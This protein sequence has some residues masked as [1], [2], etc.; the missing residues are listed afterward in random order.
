[1][2]LRLL[3]S[4]HPRQQ[5]WITRQSYRYELLSSFTF[6]APVALVEGAVVGILAVK[7][8]DVGPQLFALI[9]AAPM[10]ANL[11][12]FAWARLARGRRKVRFIQ[13]LMVALLLTVGAIA[14]LPTERPGSTL[15]AALVVAG[16]CLQAGILTIRSTVWR[17]N[18]PRAVRAQVSGRLVWVNSLVNA[19]G[20]L[21]GYMILDDYPE[22]FRVI[23][24]A[25]LLLGVVGVIAFA[26]VRLRGERE[27]LR[28]E[29]R[30][31]AQP[32]PHGAPGPIY[33][34]DPRAAADNFWTV[35]R[36]DHYYR[37]YMLWQFI[38]GMSAMMADVVIIYM[39]AE[40]TEAL[41]RQFLVSILLGA[42]VPTVVSMATMPAWARFLD[43]AHVV[44]VRAYLAVLWVL[45]ALLYW[46]AAARAS[47]LIIA[48]GRVAAGVFRGG[49]ALAW[50]LGHNDF[51]DRRLVALYMGIHVTLTGVRGAIGAFLAMALYRGWSADRLDWLGLGDLGFAGLGHQVFVVSV[52]LGLVSLAGFIHLDR[53][54]HRGGRPRAG[55]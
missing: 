19:V 23:Y 1:M 15:L 21:I 42:V 32:S 38:G 47:L 53:N 30:P 44:R 14:L 51:A 48:I 41:S 35:L 54:I 22:A 36:R 4:F 20:P 46:L 31:T 17:M 50:N 34:Y 29:R 33:E 49:G 2:I 18:Y 13:W 26:R 45:A 11:T 28:F 24:P 40:L 43:R 3:S 37:S 25:S 27:L 12:S 39:I 6:P 8:F 16:R 7:I 55:G 52:A 10:F 9:M 5:P